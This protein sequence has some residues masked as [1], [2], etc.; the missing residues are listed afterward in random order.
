M[1]LLKWMTIVNPFYLFDS[2]LIN[3]KSL[4]QFTSRNSK[5]DCRVQEGMTTHTRYLICSTC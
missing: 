5:L 4:Y 2:Y 1:M 3:S